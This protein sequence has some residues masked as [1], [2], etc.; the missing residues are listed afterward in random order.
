MTGVTVTPTANHAGATITVNTGA[1]T[2]GSASGSQSLNVGAN[3]I[4]IVVTAQDGSTKKTYTVTVTRA[5]ALSTDATLSGLT[6]SA[7][8]LSPAFTSAGITYTASVG[9]SVS[10]VTVTPTANHAGATITVNTGAVTSG[11]ASGSQSLNAGGD[12]D[13]VIEVTAQDG[14]TK[15]TYT[16]TVTRAA[17]AAS[18]D[19]TLSGLTISAGA[20]SPAFT[21]AGITYTVSV[22][23]S[24]TGITVTSTANHAGATITVNT[25]AVTSGSASGSQS[26]NAG[27]D[28]D[29]V[30]EVTAQDGS[31]K[32]TYTVTVTR[33]AAA[34]STD[35]TL[36][37]LI[38]S[39]GA[40][41]PS[42]D[43]D[44]YTY[45]VSLPF[46]IDTVTI[47]PTANDPN[48]TIRVAG[49]TV[50]SGRPCRGQRLLFMG[51]NTI[52]IVV[53]AED[54][55]TTE[56]YT[57]RITRTS[58][59]DA[60]GDTTLSGLTIDQL[61]Y[62][63][64]SRVTLTPAFHF[65]ESL[66]TA[67]VGTEVT[68]VIVT[69]TANDPNA[70]I[71]VAI[72]EKGNV[73]VP[74][75]S[76]SPLRHVVVGLNTI[77]IKVTAED[78]TS[79]TYRVRIT[80]IPRSPAL[81]N[82][83]TLSGLTV[84]PGTLS[85]GYL[86]KGGIGYNV[87]VPNRVSSVTLTPTAKDPSATITV[88]GATVVSGNASTPQNLAEGGNTILIAV[89]AEDGETKMI[90]SIFVVRARA[91]ILS[92]EGRLR[93]L[94]ISDGALNPPFIFGRMLYSV[95]VAN[96]VDEVTVT[97]TVQDPNAT[98]K[99]R[100]PGRR[101]VS[102]ASGAVSPAL[103]LNVGLNTIRI[104]VTAEDTEAPRMVYRL[105]VTRASP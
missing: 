6:I 57:V 26:L 56:T 99:V 50:A 42:F 24:V 66:Y 29:I 36:S 85:Q 73:I 54:G 33:A 14:S 105:E 69:P 96:S 9:N 78:G 34:G 72:P 48:A 83:A 87:D 103:P 10:G 61:S 27:G 19:A 62:E 23:N 71:R 47:T 79:R 90:Y 68:S 97:P 8:A 75:G 21:S 74:S 7:G 63:G 95:E 45:D 67:S 43:K 80:R 40:L 91:V 58:Y 53:T 2:S 59:A 88:G 64:V 18:T 13:I 82:D 35:A 93:A 52:D 100:I 20:L 65:L 55:A 41:S 94:T 11:S 49:D 76:A 25:G 31:T 51:M 12:T 28:T 16:V 44:T 38:I 104:I 4:T 102:V 1:V 81:S 30:I 60:S 32:K 70:T 22:G 17:A 89:T 39:H 3:T 84:S 98:I 77:I 15:K 86:Y 92:T 46:N 101:D 37:G 5:A